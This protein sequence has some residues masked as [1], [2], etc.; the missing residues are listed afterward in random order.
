MISTFSKASFL[1]KLCFLFRLLTQSSSVIFPGWAVQCFL[2]S[3]LTTTGSLHLHEK[4]KMHKALLGRCLYL[5]HGAWHLLDLNELMYAI[6]AVSKGWRA[7]KASSL[8]EAILFLG[9]KGQS[10]IEIS[11]AMSAGLKSKCSFTDFVAIC[12][13]FLSLFEPTFSLL[14]VRTFLLV[15]AQ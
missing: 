2:C 11:Y 12:M 7:L 13:S 6:P 4:S 9:G 1:P 14:L 10:Y 8:D 5:Q 3:H 15:A